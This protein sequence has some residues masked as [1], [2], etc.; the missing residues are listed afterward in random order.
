MN[1]EDILTIG[2]GDILKG[3]QVEW[4]DSHQNKPWLPADI[5]KESFLVLEQRGLVRLSDETRRM[6]EER[7]AALYRKKRALRSRK[8]YTRKRGR[9][10]PKKKAATRRRRLEKNWRDNPFGCMIN[11]YGAHSL[12]RAL[13]DR[14]IAPLW[15]Q[16]RPEDLKV[17]KAKRDVYGKEFGTKSNPYTIYSLMVV[18]RTKG[19]VFDGASLELYELSS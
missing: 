2:L 14:H 13:W 10:H 8:P 4:T 11:G 1:S 5:K 15:Q 3:I 16:Y 18:H 17:R 6:E 7:L 19:V 9:V 12:D